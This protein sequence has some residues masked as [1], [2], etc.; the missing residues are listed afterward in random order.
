MYWYYSVLS[1]ANILIT[2]SSSRATCMC[3]LSSSVVKPSLLAF[4]NQIPARNPL[5]AWLSGC[6]DRKRHGRHKGSQ[7]LV[8]IY[9]KARRHITEDSKLRSYR[10]ENVKFHV[11]T[12]GLHGQSGLLNI[13][14]P[15][16]FSKDRSRQN[17]SYQP[18]YL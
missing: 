6:M 16:S 12:V 14:L 18:S 10:C 11:V 4:R 7:R 1:A 3:C 17:G 13:S 5:R 8:H 15:P 9:Q 2:Q